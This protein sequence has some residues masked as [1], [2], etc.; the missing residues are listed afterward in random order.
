MVKA[1]KEEIIPCNTIWK[2]LA[3]IAGT[4]VLIQRLWNDVFKG[5]VLFYFFN[6][7]SKIDKGC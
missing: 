2:V 4:F 5:C 7:V 1:K 6:R 3:N